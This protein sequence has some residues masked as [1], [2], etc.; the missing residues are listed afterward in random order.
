MEDFYEIDLS[1]NLKEL[2]VIPNEF[3]DC[4][5]LSH[6]IEHLENGEDVLLHFFPKLKRGVIYIETPS[7]LSTYLLNLKIGLNFYSDP[8]HI[9]IYPFADIK[10]FFK[11]KWIFYY[12]IRH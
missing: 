11:G 9:K 2:D 1:S 12:Q 6:I 10:S 5:I 3:F 4:L 7:L 8:T